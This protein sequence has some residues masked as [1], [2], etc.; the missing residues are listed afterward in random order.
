MSSS[1]RTSFRPSHVVAS[2]PRKSLPG[3]RNIVITRQAGFTAEGAEVAA[4]PAE[5]LR[6]AQP[7]H[8]AALARVSLVVAD[9]FHFAGRWQ[10][11]DLKPYYPDGAAPLVQG[12][13]VNT[14]TTYGYDSVTM[15]QETKT[16]LC[17][18]AKKA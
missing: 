10:G 18:V 12:E 15:M 16:T 2:V 13:A 9:A 6:L 11:A 8:H 4:T 3:R 5:A 14:A 1:S 17:Q 7:D